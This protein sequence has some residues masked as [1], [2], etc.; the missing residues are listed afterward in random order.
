[1]RKYIGK[2]V[3]HVAAVIYIFSI[4]IYMKIRHPMAWREHMHEVR[5]KIREAEIRKAAKKRMKFVT[6]YTYGNDTHDDY[7]KNV[8]L[9]THFASGG[10]IVRSNNNVYCAIEKGFFD[11]N[12]TKENQQ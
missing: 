8:Q 9:V 10:T 5:I 12:G 6:K 2:K 1:M 7:L 11:R 4:T 3:L